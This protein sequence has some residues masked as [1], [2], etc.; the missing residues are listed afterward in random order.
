MNFDR[1]PT[2]ESLWCIGVL[3]CWDYPTTLA[4]SAWFANHSKS[5]ICCSFMICAFIY[6]TVE[7]VF[8]LSYIWSHVWGA[9]KYSGTWCG[10]YYLIP[11]RLTALIG[12]KILDSTVDEVSE[13]LSMHVASLAIQIVVVPVGV[14][15]LLGLHNPPR[16][17][18]GMV[19]PFL[20]GFTIAPCVDSLLCYRLIRQPKSI[21]QDSPEI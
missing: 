11:R 6:H 4:W 10:D 7:L 21:L 3:A 1:E 5:F 15:V 12:Q 19:G 18:T 17:W 8:V 14:T 2:L 16:S 13:A 20:P 9:I